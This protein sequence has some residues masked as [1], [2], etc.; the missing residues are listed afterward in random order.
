MA[1]TLNEDWDMACRRFDAFWQREI[2]DRP[3]LSLTVTQQDVPPASLRP[4][5]PEE[6][7]SDPETF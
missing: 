5:S 1:G 2:V 6:Y 3:C 4:V 7:W